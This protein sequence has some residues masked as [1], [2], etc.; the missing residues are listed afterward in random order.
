MT[1]THS[2]KKKIMKQSL[3]NYVIYNIILNKRLSADKT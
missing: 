1:Q 3:K 2:K